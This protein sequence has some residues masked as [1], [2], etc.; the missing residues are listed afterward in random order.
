M[1]E[2]DAEIGL[3]SNGGHAGFQEFSHF[4]MRYWGE[5]TQN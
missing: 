1:E 3:F 4:G 2:L 5:Y